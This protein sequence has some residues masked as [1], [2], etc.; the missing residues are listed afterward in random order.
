MRSVIRWIVLI[1]TV[2]VPAGVL[3]AEPNIHDTRLLTQP[4]SRT[5]TW[6]SSMP[7]ACGSPTSTAERPAAHRRRGGHLPGLFAGRSD[8]CFQRPIRREHRRLHGSDQRRLADPA[9]LAP[10]ADI[11]RGFTPDGKAVL[12]ASPRQ[13]VHAPLHAIVHGAA[14]RR[15][16]D[17]TADPPRGR[18][19]LL[20]R[21]PA[22]RL[23][24]AGRPR[25]QWKHYRGGTHSRIWIFHRDNH[26]VEEIPQP[27]PC[28]N[29]LDPN[30]IGEVVYFRS[31][32]NGEFNLF[33]FDTQ[34]ENRRATHPARRF[35]GGERRLGRRPAV[36]EQA[37]YLH[38]F[39]PAAGTGTRLKIGVATDLAD[40]RPRYLK[41]AAKYIRDAG[42]SPSGARAVFEY[43]GEIVTV[44]AE[45]GDP[46]NLTDSPGVNDRSPAWSPDGKSIAW[47]SDEGGEYRL[48]VKPADGKGAAKSYD[49]HGAGLLHRPRL[50]A[51]QPKNRLYRQFAVGSSG[52]ISAADT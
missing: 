3:W 40:S 36:Y 45:K 21:R 49:P 23:Y 6:R 24:A 25:R 44:P 15:H 32:R 39:D 27:Q 17:A 28:C 16:A 51:R 26:R 5:G 52:S 18:S 41:G 13:R 19:L 9:D 4:A 42:I 35:P 29:D 50:V 47:F 2:L 11:A 8:D 46:R 10:G 20:A 33:A 48:R 22:D 30:W 12:F 43:R 34:R 1:L 37:G 31:D 38:L 7:T 14:R